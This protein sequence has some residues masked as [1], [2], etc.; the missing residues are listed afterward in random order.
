MKK[1]EIVVLPA[2]PVRW[3]AGEEYK[4]ADGLTD[5]VAASLIGRGLAVDASPVV[6][7]PAAKKATTRKKAPAKA[8]VKEEVAEEAT[9]EE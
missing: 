3:F 4:P 6:K 5:E 9:K 2:G 7:K 8:T 1:D